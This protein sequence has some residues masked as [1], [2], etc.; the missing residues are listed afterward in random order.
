MKTN[1]NQMRNAE[2]GLRN[3][4]AAVSA[5]NS[6]PT[7]HSAL[8]APLAFTLVELLVVISIIG[9]LAALIFP[10]AGAV[11]RQ[12]YLKTAAAEMGEIETALDNY[13]AQYGVY[14]PSNPSLSPL[15]NTLYYELSGVTHNAA[16]KTYTTLDNACTI[17]EAAYGN[18]FTVGASSIGGIINC[19]KGSAED[20]VV[21]KNFLPSLRANR[22]GTSMTPS[23]IMI[24]NLI[25][26][27]R[28]PDIGYK[29]LGVPDVNPFR[30]V[31]PGTNSV[32]SYDLWVQLVIN[33]KTNLICNWNKQ[34]QIN[35]PLP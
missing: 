2:C 34:V 28:G 3:K 21:A 1:T 12:Q 25:T 26:S 10:V 7:P 9:V 5:T 31:Y 33:G 11:K 8:R 13:K 32:N 4:N 20:G 14:P 35:N 24:T 22:Y 19:T 27:V 23:G 17:T 18:A 16:A 15:Y 29:P 30:Y 6:F